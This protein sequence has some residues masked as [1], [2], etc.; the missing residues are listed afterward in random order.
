MPWWSIARPAPEQVVFDV[1]NSAFDSA[2]Q[3]CSA[4]RLLCIQEDVAERVLTMLNGAMQEL[5]VGNPDLLSTDVGPVI[6]EEAR[7]GI[8]E[9]ISTMREA[10]FRVTQSEQS[11]SLLGTFVL[12]TIIEIEQAKDLEREIFGPVL[13]VMRFKRSELDGLIDQINERGYGLTFGVHTRLDETVQRVV[14]RIHAGNVYVNR[15]MV[16]AVVGV[17]P[18]GGEGLSGT[19]PKAGGPLYLRR[20]LSRCPQNLPLQHWQE[21]GAVLPGPTGEANIYQLHPR[22]RVLCMPVSAQGWQA[23]RQACA[24]SGSQA[25]LLDRLGLGGWQEAPAEQIAMSD[26]GEADYDAVLFEGDSDE[27]RQVLGQVAE[28]RGPIVGVQGLLTQELEGG[29]AYVVERLLREVS[30]STNTAAAGG[31][32]SLMMVG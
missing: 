22:G 18:F 1:L 23:Q 20:L 16:G 4:L 19:G 28:R 10:G 3:R 30:V 9:H 6:D 13:H 26:L 32:A 27:L 8:E 25:I 2:G 29:A 21:Q 5:S 15:N 14:S 12:P 24:Q 7:A 11:R 31:N 17:Q